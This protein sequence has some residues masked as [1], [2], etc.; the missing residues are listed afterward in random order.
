[1]AAIDSALSCLQ[2]GTHDL[3]SP[4]FL[5]QLA[6]QTGTVFRQTTLTPGNTLSLFV[7]QIAHGNVACAAVTHL[8]GED[9]TDMAW[10]EARV[11]L[12]EGLIRQLNDRVLL[13]VRRVSERDRED[14][15]WRGHRVVVI[16]GSS[17]S[18]PDTPP[19]REHYGVPGACREGLGFPTSHLILLMDHHSGVML[20]CHD[21]HGDTHDASAASLTHDQLREGDVVLGDDAFASYVHLALLLQANAHAIVPTQHKRLIDFTPGRDFVP[22]GRNTHR[23]AR[24]KT[25]GEQLRTLGKDDQL[26]RYFKPR[27]KPDWMDEAP[28]RS[29]PE[30]IV[31]REI[32]RTIR[33]HGFRPA[34]FTVVTTLLDPATY[35]ADDIVELRLT[36]WLIETNLRHLKIT[37]GMR[38]LKCKTLDGVRKER[39]VFLLVYNF[40]RLLMLHAA[41]RQNVHVN[42][43]SFADTL[44]W[45]RL[46]SFDSMPILKVNPIR[47]G[48]LEPR[49]IKGQ[50]GKFPYMTKPRAQLQMELRARHCDTA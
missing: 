19:L 11:R 47:K 29:I 1:M 35:P 38:R 41:R 8:A 45:L 24:G 40:I 46:A 23:A 39:L 17:D 34:T 48:R 3:L 27:N 15:H 42:R 26:V 9:F 16:D 31:V 6:R 32:R 13:E 25:R 12:K 37:L 2:K 10:C 36:R 20:D 49:A 22:Q 4:E 21:L 5:N 30:S 18:M 28:W 50:G 43:I 14:S 33:R 7:R 44:A